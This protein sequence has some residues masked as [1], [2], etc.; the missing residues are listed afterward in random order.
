MTDYVI[1]A[2]TINK[3]VSDDEFPIKFVEQLIKLNPVGY[4]KEL[5]DVK[6]EPLSDKEYDQMMKYRADTNECVKIMII[7]I[8]DVSMVLGGVDRT[9]GNIDKIMKSQ[10][11]PEFVKQKIAEGKL[12]HTTHN[13]GCGCGG[14][15]YH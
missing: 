2:E 7:G 9:M 13:A 5:Y 14:H 8:P 11:I 1:S 12:K 15:H 10:R 3:M 4:D 6:I